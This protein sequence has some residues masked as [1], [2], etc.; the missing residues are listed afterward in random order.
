MARRRNPKPGR[1]NP[2]PET[3]GFSSKNIL[4]RGQ[5]LL[6]ATPS[7]TDI[8]DAI[9]KGRRAP[10]LEEA[11]EV[12]KLPDELPILE[13]IGTT[14]KSSSTEEA[15]RKRRELSVG[16]EEA[17]KSEIRDKLT[18]PGKSDEMY[19]QSDP[20]TCVVAAFMNI[21][22]RFGKFPDNLS[23]AKILEKQYVREAIAMGAYGTKRGKEGM[24]LAGTQR[25][26]EQAT[27][28]ETFPPKSSTQLFE[29]LQDGKCA[30]IFKNMG[31]R[32]H[33][34]VLCKFD[35]T[36]VV[37]DPDNNA[38]LSK[39]QRIEVLPVSQKTVDTLWSETGDEAA[40]VEILIV[41]DIGSKP[42]K[43]GAETKEKERVIERGD[44]LAE[45]E[46]QINDI[47]TGGA[48][49]E[50]GEQL[51]RYTEGKNR[52]K[53]V[54]EK[55]ARQLNINEAYTNALAHLSPDQVQKV[56]G[57]LEA[58][59][60]QKFGDWKIKG[61]DWSTQGA[62][63]AGLKKAFD[64]DLKRAVVAYDL[65]RQAKER[66][67]GIDLQR[68][69]QIQKQIEQDEAKL[70]AAPLSE[71]EHKAIEE[72]LRQAKIGLR[73]KRTSAQDKLRLRESVNEYR[74][75]LAKD[76]PL[77]DAEKEEITSRL[78]TNWN[79]LTANQD[80]AAVTTAHDAIKRDAQ[81]LYAEGATLSREEK[82]RLRE[83]LEANWAIIT[84]TEPDTASRVRQKIDV[85]VQALKDA[86]DGTLAWSADKV[87]RTEK[88]LRQNRALLDTM[89]R[90][91]VGRLQDETSQ[92]MRE[93]VH[94]DKND[95]PKQAELQG[96]LK[97][98]EERL[99]QMR[100][101]D[102]SPYL[103]F[104][105]RQ[106]AVRELTHLENVKQ[107][108]DA[109]KQWL[110]NKNVETPKDW[111]AVEAPDQQKIEQ[112]RAELH[113]LYKKEAG[114]LKEAIQ[115]PHEA[116]KT[117]LESEIAFNGALPS[118]LDAKLIHITNMLEGKLN[119]DLR[120]FVDE[121]RKRQ[122][123]APLTDPEWDKLSSADSKEQAKLFRFQEAMALSAMKDLLQKT[124]A[125]GQWENRPEHDKVVRA[126]RMWVRRYKK[127]P[128][129][130]PK[131]FDEW[132]HE[133][134]DENSAGSTGARAA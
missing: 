134:D 51:P 64:I 109:E 42:K 99:T 117:V 36:F 70:A 11:P 96:A 125:A 128:T 49:K 19:K 104:L 65:L 44:W 111:K 68:P 9:A 41:G 40:A 66:E 24:T 89:R 115:E 33:A 118:G 74:E 43:N 28:Y 35:N 87:Q 39:E 81:L 3:G 95:K 12:I 34:Y 130:S 80:T 77:T 18:E 29:E 97:K 47:V 126:L 110:Q 83:Q 10:R 103:K 102:T 92:L 27:P 124:N 50:T 52:G 88:R 100:A 16:L 32:R 60:A 101:V 82:Q 73:N 45:K 107:V 120:E 76:T 25:F 91:R 114:Y 131:E 6:S 48:D 17:K 113:E 127:Y 78:E 20:K 72:N 98:N 13:S 93:L 84:K 31:G 61:A 7:S 108:S 71:I 90:G 30:M 58:V 63:A 1:S 133:D 38:S 85:D 46:E 4:R 23:E 121:G 21:M 123:K 106:A 57:E 37:I 62:Y 86:R 14:E 53:V 105:R 56:T 75:R 112:T 2:S 8:V 116:L 22:K 5:E 129:K 15:A 119:A 67:F 55:R 54:K 26:I 122:G 79:L 69:S 59:Y 132:L 94:T